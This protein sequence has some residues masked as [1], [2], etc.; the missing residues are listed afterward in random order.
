MTIKSIIQIIVTLLIIIIIGGVY[1]KYF[2]VETSIV[3]EVELSNLENT[4]RIE[5]LEKKLLELQ[6]QNKELNEKIIFQENIANKNI[7]NTTVN[8]TSKKITE[9]QELVLSDQIQDKKQKEN[10]VTTIV[11]E[12]KTITNKP[13]IKNLVKDVEYTSVDQKGNKFYLLASSGKSNSEN[14]DVLDLENVRGEI[15]SETRDTIFI[16]SDY[17]QYNSLNLNSKFFGNVIIDYQDKKINCI[18]FDINMET[19]KA[20][21]YNNVIIKDP[22]S[23]MKAG[24]VEFDLKTKDVNINPNYNTE[25]IKVVTN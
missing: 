6:S 25:K 3:E 14:K 22:K 20:I 21:A 4:D 18:N 10:K 1:F 5:E 23:T 11:S 17:A 19:N 12:E 15:R 7:S 8:E 9:S 24:I 13:K 2:K 16:T